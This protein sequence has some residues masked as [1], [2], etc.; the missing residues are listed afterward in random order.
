MQKGHALGSTRADW[1]YP[2]A[3]WVDRAR[4]L[5][6]METRWS[7]MMAEGMDPDSPE[8][9]LGM[10]QWA[11]ARDEGEKV[12]RLADLLFA[13]VGAS[14]VDDAGVRK[15]CSRAAMLVASKAAEA[16]A[17]ATLQRRARE[18][19][20]AHLAAMRRWVAGDASAAEPLAMMLEIIQTDTAYDPVRGDAAL[21]L[22]AADEAL[23]WRK[24]WE[25][26]ARDLA[27]LR[28]K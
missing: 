7:Q 13:E 12:L 15:D 11:S 27:A 2:S 19:L 6:E 1:E 8:E 3:Q 21:G 26:L 17:R 23:A 16:A 18:E 20:S 22:L 10:L 24:V 14:Y 5:A 28:S 9:Q 4:F 25:E